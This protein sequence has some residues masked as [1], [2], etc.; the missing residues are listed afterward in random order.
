MFTVFFHLSSLR[1]RRRRRAYHFRCS[2]FFSSSVS[3][4][5]DTL[6]F[7]FIQNARFLD[8][9]T[10]KTGG[11]RVGVSD[12]IHRGNGR[13]G[14]RR[15]FLLLLLFLARFFLRLLFPERV[16][17]RSSFLSR[18][19]RRRRRRKTHILPP[20][21]IDKYINTARSRRLEFFSRRS[22]LRFYV[23]LVFITVFSSSSLYCVLKV[24]SVF[25]V[26]EIALAFSLGSQTLNPRPLFSSRCVNSYLSAKTTQKEL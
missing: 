15:R 20:C 18:R 17:S 19:G 10:N 13:R 23:V 1:R 5:P 25:C 21:E 8:A 16:Q 11:I 22:F 4:L 12:T 14:K 9:T 26:L 2:C 24:R 3:N 7:F 6:R